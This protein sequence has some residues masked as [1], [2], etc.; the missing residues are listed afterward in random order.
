MTDPAS[1]FLS[2]RIPILT[3]RSLPLLVEAGLTEVSY[4]YI[5]L[6]CQKEV[7]MGGKK[8]NLVCLKPGSDVQQ[9][10]CVVATS[11]DISS[12]WVVKNSQLALK[13]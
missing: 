5:Y 11:M 10:R 12:V 9:L 2:L 7:G 3:I 8:R 4:L 6:P 1:S 13:R